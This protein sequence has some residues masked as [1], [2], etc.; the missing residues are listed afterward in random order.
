MILGMGVTLI[1]IYED[2]AG[3]DCR[4]T[5]LNPSLGLSPAEHRATVHDRLIPAWV[6][7]VVFQEVHE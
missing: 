7:H 2:K 6:S 5:N 1:A 4:A 3:L